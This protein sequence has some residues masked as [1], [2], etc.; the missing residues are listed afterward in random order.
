MVIN[1]IIS[2]ILVIKGIKTLVGF[3]SDG[4]LLAIIPLGAEIYALIMEGMKI[5]RYLSKRF[6][7]SIAKAKLRQL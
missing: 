6:P 2:F 7:K 3:E 1:V 5:V 4:A